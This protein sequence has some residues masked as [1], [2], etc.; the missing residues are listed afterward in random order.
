VDGA[1]D[2]EKNFLGKVKGLV[3]IA[4]QVQG[5]L[6]HHPFVAG[7]EFGASRGLARG[8]S[9]D[10]RRLVV[11]HFNPSECS[12]VFHDGIRNGSNAHGQCI[13]IRTRPRPKVPP[14][15]GR[16]LGQTT[17]QLGNTP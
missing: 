4:K 14:R 7:H 17:T 5:K 3:P 15:D 8:A 12:G 1:E 13:N 9:L 16:R 10:E 2:A 6:E 11:P